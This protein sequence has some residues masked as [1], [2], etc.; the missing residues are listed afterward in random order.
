MLDWLMS[1][2]KNDSWRRLPPGKHHIYCHY[3]SA[4]ES[5][6]FTKSETSLQLSDG[7]RH[8]SPCPCITSVCLCLI[9]SLYIDGSV[10]D[11]SNS[12]SSAREL[13]Q[14]CAKPPICTWLPHANTPIQSVVI[15]AYDRNLQGKPDI[16]IIARTNTWMKLR[17]IWSDAMSSTWEIKGKAGCFD[18][19]TA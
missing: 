8:S 14:S 17:C 11:C 19:F 3:Y 12:R 1:V 15:I 7:D 6:T 5:W 9:I 13:L 16:L 4:M 18:I 10:Q 2:S